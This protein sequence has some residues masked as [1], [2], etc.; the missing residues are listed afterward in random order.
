MKFLWDAAK[1]RKKILKARLL[2]SPMR[3]RYSKG[4]ARTPQYEGGLWRE[5][6]GGNRQHS[7]TVAVI[8]ARSGHHSHHLVEK[9]K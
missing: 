4:F 1:N 3:P 2:T 6:A 5:P 7:R 9:S 8:A